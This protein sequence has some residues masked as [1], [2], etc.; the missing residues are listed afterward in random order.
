MEGWEEDWVEPP[1]PAGAAPREGAIFSR[2]FAKIL[3]NMRV[4]LSTLREGRPIATPISASA[5]GTFG[6]RPLHA[7]R[8][9]VRIALEKIW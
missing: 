7:A 8:L 3:L 1:D 4:K 2:N 5:E 9:T 6:K